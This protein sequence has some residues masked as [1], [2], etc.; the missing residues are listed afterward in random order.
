MNESRSPRPNQVFE[1]RDHRTRNRRVRILREIAAGNLG[2]RRFA[3]QIIS[4]DG[5]P[6][7]VGKTTTLSEHTLARGFRLVE[8]EVGNFDPDELEDTARQVHDANP[9]L[10]NDEAHALAADQLRRAHP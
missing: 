3:A 10:T 6:K 2:R 1:D 5:T 4:D 7:Q 9:H 8:Q